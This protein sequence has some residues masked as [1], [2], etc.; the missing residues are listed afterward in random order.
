MGKIQRFLPGIVDKAETSGTKIILDSNRS[1]LES[2]GRS[3]FNSVTG[4]L[5][6]AKGASK[7]FGAQKTFG[8]Q[9]TLE[10][11]LR[12]FETRKAEIEKKLKS[13]KDDGK[14]NIQFKD[15]N[16]NFRAATDDEKTAYNVLNKRKER[17]EDSIKLSKEKGA[18]VYDPKLFSGTERFASMFLND[19][20]KYSGYKIAGGI[21]GS[22]MAANIIGHGSLGIPLLSTASWNR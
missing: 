7:R 8:T 4:F 21:A 5:G 1:I 11:R 3:F 17:L 2:Y 20:G 6:N 22:Y 10:E 19:E 14:G 16:G 12:P 15:E 18:A 9:K 13:Y